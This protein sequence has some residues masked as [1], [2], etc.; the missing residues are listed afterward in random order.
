MP[1]ST[2]QPNTV[3]QHQPGEGSPPTDPSVAGGPVVAAVGGDRVLAI[4]D[5]AGWAF[6]S[7]AKSLAKSLRDRF[8]IEHLPANQFSKWTIQQLR[9]YLGSFDLIYCFSA[10]MPDDVY[11]VLSVRPMVVG[12]HSE[13]SM[14]VNP[15]LYVPSRFRRF[16]A[17]GCVNGR[18]AARCR[19]LGLHEQVLV[20]S[21]GVD[22]E[23]FTPPEGDTRPGAVVRC[24]WSG[25]IQRK[26]GDIKRF[27]ELVTASCI[28]AGVPLVAATRE[29]SHVP[30]EQM[31]DYYKL[32]DVYLCAST[33]EGSQGPLVEAAASG[34]ALISTRVGIAEELI[35]DGVNGF[36]VEPTVGAIAGRLHWCR[37]HP[38]QVREMG[39]AARETVLE[40]WTWRERAGVYAELFEIGLRGH[41]R[42]RASAAVSIDTGADHS[43]ASVASA[44]DAE[45]A[46]APR[47]SVLIPNYN[48][49]S[50]S[51]QMGDRDLLGELLQSLE[52][53]LKD[54]PTPFEVIAYDDG[55]T[56][57]SLATLRRWAGRCWPDGR[58]FLELIEAPH[59]GVLSRTANVL[60]RK[61]RGDILARLDGDVVCLTDRWVSKLVEVFDTGPPRLG[62][63]GP[64][65][66]GPE[67]RIHAFGDWLLH[68]NGYTHV[69]NGLPRDAV[70]Q[71]LEVDH[72]MGCF[73][74]CKKAVFEDL[75]GYDERFLRG[76]TVDFGVRA[77][78]K[79]W[80]CIAV[81]QIEF[82][83]N[84]ALRKF[85]A[86]TADSMH[87]V[88]DSLRVFRDK[89]GFSRLAPDLDEVRQRYAGTPLLWN[90]RWFAGPYDGVPVDQSEPDTPAATEWGLYETDDAFRGRVDSRLA[91]VLKLAGERG[92]QVSTTVLG[93]ACGL[94]PHLLV[95]N[96]LRCFALE[97]G[98]GNVALARRCVA[99][100]TYTGPGPELQ[101]WPDARVLPLTDR[102]VGLL[103]VVEEMERHPNPVVLLR[104]AARVLEEDG[105][106][107]LISR[108]R[109]GE[110]GPTDIGHPYTLQELVSQVHGAGGWSVINDAE[111][112]GQDGEIVVVAKQLL[113]A[114]PVPVTGQGPVKK[115]EL[116]PA[117]S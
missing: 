14:Q 23:L 106:L 61:A 21:N 86:T 109:T 63:V 10:I 99:T 5:M 35:E 62:V 102:C 57:D 74:C 37:E 25:A 17:V 45:K 93:A 4:T 50:Q 96:G 1:R 75:D 92:N 70:T 107:V 78:L 19:E 7:I 81:P 3:E 69:A 66:L 43:A 98:A 15:N 85:R 54:D 26:E 38:E 88:V 76:Q 71:P 67:M 20:T 51:S 59:C 112:A 72:V 32:V 52:D 114:T 24:G 41:A 89:W 28:V 87:G 101:E 27:D 8:H 116:T 9:A 91:E 104:E 90:A 30:P 6:E 46:D 110:P 103:V 2:D 84:H 42:G 80:S 73:Y 79:G 34:C 53:T 31:P 40:S 111:E 39:L 49:G 36:L 47:V 94:L 22:P 105:R 64:K 56:D 33:T 108:P 48:N 83:H 44:A 82:I 117:S 11:D 60:S 97:R 113:P 115:R 16:R 29:H 65:Q 12:V 18:I 68:P 95:T 55:S 100:K 77:R 58:P 13:C